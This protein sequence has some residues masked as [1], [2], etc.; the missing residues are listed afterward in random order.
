[1]KALAC[2]LLLLLSLPLRAVEPNYA[3]RGK[4][5]FDTALAQLNPY[6]VW[7]PLESNLWVYQPLEPKPYLPYCE[8]RWLYTD[9]GWHWQGSAPHSWA[10]DHYGAWLHT[11]K[12]GWVWKPDGNWH[13]STVDFCVTKTHT[14]WR[15]SLLDRNGKLLESD[16]ARF[17][18][19]DDWIYVPTE[20]F[21]Q[22]LTRATVLNGDTSQTKALLEESN[23]LGH[24]FHAWRE[25]DRVGPDP[26]AV[27]KS[28]AT[29]FK[30]A[31][32]W[33]LPTFWSLP[34]DHILPGDLYLYRPQFFQDRDGIQRRVSVWQDPNALKKARA[35][36]GPLFSKKS[37]KD[38]NTTAPNTP[39]P[40]SG[41]FSESPLFD[42]VPVPNGPQPTPTPKPRI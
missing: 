40:K 13:A 5:D 11:E 29:P 7:L 19:P 31:T 3:E 23:P 22:P 20:K 25:I 14:G 16:A 37:D 41:A 4:T 26:L 10:T 35:E 30:A 42:N 12:Y 9:F 33:N 24:T 1:M 36:L 18:R 32:T 21:G 34:P 38:S 15:P 8:G 17:A 28:A 27:F 39:A 2:F 6:G